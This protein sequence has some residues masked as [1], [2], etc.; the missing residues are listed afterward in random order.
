M[1]Q[2]GGERRTG[3]RRRL[4]VF[5][6]LIFRALRASL[7]HVQSFYA[8]V[9]VFITAGAALAIAGSWAFASVGFCSVDM[10]PP[11]PVHE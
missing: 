1:T 11:G 9:G 8:A 5:W 7:T 6:N 3:P 2:P 10:N 4:D